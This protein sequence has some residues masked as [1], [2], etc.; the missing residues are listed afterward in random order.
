MSEYDLNSR[1]RKYMQ[2]K[3]QVKDT[4]RKRNAANAQHL[5]EQ[6]I[7]AENKRLTSTLQAGLEVSDD[8]TKNKILGEIDVVTERLRDMLPENL[9]DVGG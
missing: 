1:T 5:L 7:D 4:T 3:A 2:K 8:I 6:K 9:R